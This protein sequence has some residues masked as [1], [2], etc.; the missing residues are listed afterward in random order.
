MI[1]ESRQARKKEGAIQECGRSGDGAD[2]PSVRQTGAGRGDARRR[3]RETEEKSYLVKKSGVRQGGTSE[4]G[5]LRQVPGSPVRPGR[6]GEC[7]CRQMMQPST[8]PWSPCATSGDAPRTTLSTWQIE[9]RVGCR[10]LAMAIT[11]MSSG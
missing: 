11:K 8:G 3:K 2:H 9:Y 6:A 7:I 5:H 10:G 1:R 4:G